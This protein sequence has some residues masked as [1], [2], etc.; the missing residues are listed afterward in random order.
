M[1]NKKVN[2]QVRFAN[3]RWLTG[4]CVFIVG[5]AYQAADQFGIVPPFPQDQ[6]VSFLTLGISLFFGAYTG[7]IDP[8]TEGTGDSELALG[9]TEPRKHFAGQSGDVEAIAKEGE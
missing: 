2:W 8:T 7:V 1:K 5:V 9:Y 3:K 6:I 4:F